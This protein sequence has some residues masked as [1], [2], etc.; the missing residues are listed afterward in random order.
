MIEKSLLISEVFFPLGQEE[1]LW[2]EAAQKVLEIG[3][4][5]R[6]EVAAVKEAA[7]RRL[8][9]RMTRDAGVALTYW[10]IPTMTQEGLGLSSPDKALRLRTLQ[11]LRQLLE[12]GAECGAALIGI[13]S[14]PD[15]GP[16]HREESTRWLTES[17]LTLK[18]SL[19]ALPGIALLMEPLD[20][21]VHKKQLIGPIE[22]AA[23]LAASLRKEGV[24]FYLCWDSAHEALGGADLLQSY[25]LAA[26]YLGQFHLC[27]AVTV[28]GQPL[29]GDFHL[30]PGPP[31]DFSS[32]G[33]LTLPL[34]TALLK[35]AK[36]LAGQT[37]RP[38]SVTLEART[39]PGQNVWQTEGLV[40]AFLT[41]CFE[42]AE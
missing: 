26:P 15:S 11:R 1:N 18:P 30:P 35:Q 9:R 17:I 8:L 36:A 23:A 31:P 32:S 16:G 5:Q 25:A 27:N 22:E 39:Q 19:D 33:Y 7:N 40:R 4:Y 37:D 21:E 20:R 34:A 42:E 6:L 3:Y 12:E 28:P 41:R 2:L 24:P 38:L 29:Y 13:P 14:G 10:T